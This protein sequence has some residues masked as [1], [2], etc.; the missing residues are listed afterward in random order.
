MRAFLILLLI[1]N[2]AYLAWSQIGGPDRAEPSLPGEGPPPFQPAAQSLVLL[3]ELPQERLNLMASLAQ[4]RTARAGAQQELEEV[5]QE[6]AQV[7]S[8]IAD[9]QAE[10]AEDRSITPWCASTGP[11]ADPAAAASFMD[12]LGDL[13]G[14]AALDLREEPISSTW[15]VH[16][17][18]FATE[19][20]AMERLAELQARNIDSYFMRNGEMAGGISLGVYS[21]RE[22]GLIAQQRL[23]DQ[24]YATSLR[25][26]FR[27]AERP[28]VGL[29]LPDDSLREAPEWSAFLASAEGVA[30]VENAC[31]TI[32]SEFEF[33]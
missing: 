20:L 3:N 21:R 15:W 30:L 25:E 7:R 1:A 9:V 2:L 24:G 11:F 22:S 29:R 6:A 33:P 18:A 28:Y 5:Q 13:G 19:A 14:E 10:L 32:A 27:M 16:M 8:D 12:A 17:P 31:E 23:A 4:A 26:V